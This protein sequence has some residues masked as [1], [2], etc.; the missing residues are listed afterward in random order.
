MGKRLRFFVVLAAAVTTLAA[1]PKPDSHPPAHRLTM[2]LW[3]HG[4][5]GGANATGPERNTT[6]PHDG[7]V[8]GK[9]VIRL[10]NVSDPTITLYEPE[11]AKR[12]GAA[13][14]VFPGGAYQILAM[15]LEGTEVCAWLNSI[16]VTAVLLK[17]RVPPRKGLPRYAAPLQDAQRALGLVRYHAREWGIDPNRIG[18]LGFSAG[19]DL[20]ALLSTH[21]AQ[22]T[23]T[24]VDGADE[25]SC[26]PDFTMLVYPAYLVVNH[27]GCA[28]A[29][30]LKV[31]A[32]TPPTFLVQTEDDPI[33]V[34]NSICY[35]LA[36]KR[37]K[38]PAE[39]HIYPAGGHGYGL[40][41]TKETV[42]TWPERAVA[43]L[44]SLGMR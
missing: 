12:S 11:K 21:F 44:R 16:G 20:G 14:V 38:V 17:Y 25:V 27:L 34:K 18:V 19:G 15:D 9:S 33:G 2:R 3:P 42:T 32:S 22:R 23:Y 39:M 6:G 1:A 28:L 36:L 40:R 31:T 13:V 30:E 7:L 8:A 26:K 24:R 4:A 37:A 29:P 35:Y 41:R 10:T 5:P 43:W